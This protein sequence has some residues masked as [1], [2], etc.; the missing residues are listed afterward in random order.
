[1]YSKEAVS[2]F[3]EESRDLLPNLGGALTRVI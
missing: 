2:P 1:M 3:K